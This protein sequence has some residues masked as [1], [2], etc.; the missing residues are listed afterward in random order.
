M[1]KIKEVINHFKTWAVKKHYVDMEKIH[2][3]NKNG[4]IAFY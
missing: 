3:V 2:A 1:N 4:V